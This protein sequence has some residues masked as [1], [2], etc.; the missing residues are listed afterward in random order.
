M[1]IPLAASPATAAVVPAVFKKFRLL[2][3]F[4]STSSSFI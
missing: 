1:G 2:I 3:D 4:F